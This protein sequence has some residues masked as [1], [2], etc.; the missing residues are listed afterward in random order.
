M[1]H[2]LSGQLVGMV[3]GF[4]IGAF[5]PGIGRMIKGWFSREAAVVKEKL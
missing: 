3:I 2:Y 4:I 5:T 1:G